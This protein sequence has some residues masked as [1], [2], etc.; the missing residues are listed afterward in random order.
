MNITKWPGRVL[1][2][3]TLRTCNSFGYH[4]LH[5]IITLLSPHRELE[6]DREGVAGE[7]IGIAI[8]TARVRCGLLECFPCVADLH[9]V[10]R[11]VL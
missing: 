9:R 8:L 10:T 5:S 2:G 3:I 11:V 1:R 7:T 6:V 4:H